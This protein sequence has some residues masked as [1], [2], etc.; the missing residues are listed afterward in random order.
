MTH[1]A[2]E[3]LRRHSIPALRLEFQ[4]YRHRA[5]G[6]RQWILPRWSRIKSPRT[7]H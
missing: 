7:P 6:A 3:P 5:T 4:E 2:F 1:P